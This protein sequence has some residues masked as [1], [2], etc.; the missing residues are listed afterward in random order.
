VDWIHFATPA[1]AGAAETEFRLRLTDGSVVTAKTVS[2]EGANLSFVL[3]QEK[4]KRQVAL[5]SVVGI[6]QLNGPVSWLSSRGAAEVVQTPY[7]QKPFPTRMD[8]SV[9]DEPSGAPRPIAAGGVTY[10]HGIGVHSYSRIDY[11]L[12]GKY[13]A[14]RTQYAIAPDEKSKS[15]DVTVRVKI[16]GKAVHEKEHVKLGVVSPVVILDVPREAKLLTLEVDYGAGF[17]YGDNFNWIEPALL[18]EKPEPPP[19]PPPPPPPATRP[20]T[21][22]ATQP[23]GLAPATR[24][25]TGPSTLPAAP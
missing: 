18:R 2:M 24:P 4:E 7:I 10:A 25:T 1:R 3:G 15:A 12:D 9:L 14:L 23:A 22:P 16:D 11:A 13:A 17:D 5:T 21:Q 19:P 6:E 20:A 8:A